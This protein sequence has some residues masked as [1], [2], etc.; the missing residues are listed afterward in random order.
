MMRALVVALAMGFVPGDAVVTDTADVIEINH[1]FDE[2][3]RLVFDQIIFWDWCDER[4]NHHVVA[5]RFAK[6]VSQRP[7]RD[8]ARGGYVTSWRDGDL[9]RRVHSASLRETWTQYDPE[10]QDRS[11]YSQ[12][13]RRGLASQRDLSQPQTDSVADER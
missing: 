12:H 11:L 6:H 2:N 1:Y 10:V 7:L 5:W 13:L 4:E 8:W 3:G 9:L